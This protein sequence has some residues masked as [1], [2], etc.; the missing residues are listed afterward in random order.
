MPRLPIIQ[1]L[2]TNLIKLP[3][4]IEVANDSENS[5]GHSRMNAIRAFPPS[6]EPTG[7]KPLLTANLIHLEH[8]FRMIW[9]RMTC[10]R[11]PS[12]LP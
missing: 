7:P 6:T 5:A 3:L 9:F 8:G 10:A 4:N 11:I 1:V 12:T 2:M